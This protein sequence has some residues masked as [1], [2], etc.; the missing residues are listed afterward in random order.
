MSISYTTRSRGS[1][2]FPAMA[3]L[4]LLAVLIGFW[5]TFIEPVSRGAFEAPIAIYIH[6]AFAFSWVSLFTV[7]TILIRLRKFGYH[8]LLGYSGIFIA[9]GAALTMIPAGLYSVEKELAQGLGE[10]A[11]S[12]ILGVITSG[13]LFL[14]L[15]AAGIWYRKNPETHRWFMLL[16]TIVLLWPAWFRFR[17]YFPSVP[18]PQLWFGL[19]LADSLILIAIAWDVLT[20]KKVSSVLLY[21][22]LF[23]IAEQTLEVFMFDRPLWRVIAKHVYLFITY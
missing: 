3:I 19:I 13:M 1:F 9:T 6:G 14:S 17:H 23:I 8:K 12:T 7:Q 4:G 21:A 22:G 20:N 11:I 18:E 5:K 2:F 16:A 15:V 10:T